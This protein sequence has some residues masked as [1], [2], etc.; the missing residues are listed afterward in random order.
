MRTGIENTGVIIMSEAWIGLIASIGTGLLSLI[1]VYMANRKQ[2]ALIAY[3]L[4]QLEKK[5]DKHNNLIE[6]MT[7]VEG[8]VDVIE[9]EVNGK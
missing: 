2:T 4:E 1:G 8:R 9:R 6:R 3:R 7:K 5:Q